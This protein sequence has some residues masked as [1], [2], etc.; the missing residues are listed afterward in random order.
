MLTALVLVVAL[1]AR[2]DLPTSTPAAVTCGSVGYAYDAAGRLVGVQDQSGH[3]ARYDY[4]EVGNRTG[5]TN[6]GAPAVSVLSFSP[7]H[8]APGASVTISGGCFSE[9]VSDDVVSFNGT[10][11]VVTSASV[12]RLVATVPAGATTGLLSV[13]VAGE[14]GS[15][16]D[17]F[18][19][20]PSVG[21]PVIAGLSST[22]L[23]T[24]DTLTV[25]GTGFD[26]QPANDQ[27]WVNKTRAVV[28]SA[29]PESLT[30][31]VPGG[32]NAGRVQVETVRTQRSMIAFIPGASG[33]R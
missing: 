8:A 19:V 18:V 28:Q 20:D 33:R 4:D 24:R 15:S 31:Q 27:V 25:T 32:L 6:L 9:V 2:G 14:V 7:A 13:S 5:V 10:P 29:T 16:R 11:A 21:A 12:H 30:V 3:A 23:V 26:P 17:S 22:V 1:S